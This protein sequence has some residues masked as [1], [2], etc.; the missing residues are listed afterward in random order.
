MA[1]GIGHNEFAPVSRKEPVG[2]ING[3]ALFALS[4]K[5]VDEQSQVNA[6]A[7]GAKLAAV[8]LKGI[9][10]IFKDHLAVKEQPA[11]QG[12]LAIVH[13]AAGDKPQQA[14]GLVAF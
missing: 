12:A 6:L 7:L 5:S 4:G 2:Y 14:L 3:D 13:A 1:R 10:L 11:N 9:E 8:G